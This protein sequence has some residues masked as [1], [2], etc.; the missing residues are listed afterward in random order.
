MRKTVIHFFTIADYE[1][2]E[3]WLRELHQCGWR[4]VD[5]KPP[6]FYIFES[7]EPQ[8]VIYRLDF[9]NDTPTG[10]YMQMA[11][12][13]GWDCFFQWFG[14]LY[15]RKSADAVE[16]EGEDELFSDNE[17]RVDMAEHIYRTRLIPITVIFLCCVIPSLINAINGFMSVYSGIFGAFFGAMF[18]YYLYVVI[19]CAS[20]LNAIRERYQDRK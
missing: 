19:H 20:K 17:S 15:F 16:S 2:E 7:C 14:W 3:S 18:V 13:F 11:R 4:M 12:D 5:F 8:D 10:E 9:K 1:E 6:V